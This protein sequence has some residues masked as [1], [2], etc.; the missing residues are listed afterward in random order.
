MARLRPVTLPEMYVGMIITTMS[1]L[2]RFLNTMFPPSPPP[3]PRKQWVVKVPSGEMARR[4]RA[5]DAAHLAA[6]N[7]RKK[8]RINKSDVV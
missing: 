7:R 6:I 2:N 3:K 1:I 5:V 8:L 4:Q